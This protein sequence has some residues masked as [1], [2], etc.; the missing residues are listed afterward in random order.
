MPAL[1]VP[2]VVSAAPL[3]TTLMSAE[4]CWVSS[5]EFLDPS[6]AFPSTAPVHPPPPPMD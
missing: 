5:V 2:L 1:F 4:F 6:F 3:D